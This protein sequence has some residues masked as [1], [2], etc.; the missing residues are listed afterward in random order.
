MADDFAGCYLGYDPGGDRK[1]G[2][3]AIQSA[4]PGTDA[5]KLSVDTVNTV[6]DV[7]AWFRVFIDG[8][9]FGPVRGI[10]VDT[11]AYWSASRGGLRG[12]D[13]ALRSAFEPVK[14]SVVHPNSLY[15]A[16]SV[17]GMF[18]LQKLLALDEPYGRK[19]LYVTETHPKV[20]FFSMTGTDEEKYVDLPRYEREIATERNWTRCWKN[21]EEKERVRNVDEWPE[22][23]RRWWLEDKAARWLRPWGLL[24]EGCTGPAVSHELDA[25]VSAGAALEG[26]SRRWARNLRC[27]SHC[28]SLVTESRVTVAFDTGGWEEGDSLWSPSAEIEYRWPDQKWIEQFRHKVPER[29]PREQE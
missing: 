5:Q 12:A 23:E 13:R 3:A 21:P 29:T 20:L 27:E 19:G 16:M 24:P 9:R 8:R 2:V 14:A 1:H 15:G 11:L 28:Q 6:R 22:D 4:G 25:L 18:V 26:R 10:G 17:N 7:I